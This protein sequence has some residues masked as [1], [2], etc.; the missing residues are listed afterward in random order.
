MLSSD[1]KTVNK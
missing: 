1:N